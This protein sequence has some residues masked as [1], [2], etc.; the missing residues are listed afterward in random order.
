MQSE[1]SSSTGMIS[2]RKGL[3]KGLFFLVGQNKSNARTLQ[4]RS[5]ACHAEPPRNEIIGLSKPSMESSSSKGSSNV[6]SYSFILFCLPPNAERKSAML[7]LKDD[8]E[9]DLAVVPFFALLD[10]PALKK[11]DIEARDSDLVRPNG[12]Q[13]ISLTLDLRFWED[14]PTFG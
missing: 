7:L 9:A 10:E 2:G 6:S 12:R 11:R 1:A 4:F 3:S 13:V 8:L 5:R 14:A